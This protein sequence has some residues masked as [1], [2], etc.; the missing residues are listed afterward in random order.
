MIL[1]SCNFGAAEKTIEMVKLDENLDI[2][3][4]PPSQDS[5]KHMLNV[6]NDHCI[7]ECLRRLEDIESLSNAAQVCTRFQ[8][9][10]RE[11]FP[12]KFKRIHLD[13]QHTNLKWVKY[14]LRHFGD[15]I[16]F[17]SL[18]QIQNENKKYN[19]I[20]ELIAQNC[21][22]TLKELSIHGYKPKFDLGSK[23][24]ALRE[25]RIENTSAVIGKKCWFNQEFPQ[26]SSITINNVDGL[27]DEIL[28]DFI[29]RNPQLRV[30]RRFRCEQVTE[31]TLRCIDIRLPNL[32]ELRSTFTCLLSEDL[33]RDI[34]GLRNLKTLAIN[35]SVNYT[36][37]LCDL[38]AKKD[39]PIASLNLYGLY[40]G[41]SDDLAKL[42]Q[43]NYLTIC[44]RDWEDN[45]HTIVWETIRILQACKKLTTLSISICRSTRFEQTEID[46]N[47]YNSLLGSAEGRC[48]TFL[49]ILRC[50]VDVPKDILKA[51]RKWVFIH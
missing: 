32:Q 47:F 6:L 35:F 38:L 4:V 40:H 9:N 31:S 27:T 49:R 20:F 26:L 2:L 8:Q 3:A 37:F 21:G 7:Q 29:E 28:A 19:E 14:Y 43:L 46:L 33:I 16:Q 45:D 23:F 17:V 18:M 25:L 12:R 15:L 39:V 44:H 34:C 13:D 41:I 1:I 22:D 48:R 11:Y 51:N 30:F 24:K 36:P 50:K 10:A 42:K 5:P